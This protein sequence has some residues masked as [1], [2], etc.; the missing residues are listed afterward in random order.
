VPSNSSVLR[1]EHITLQKF[2]SDA[3]H[4]SLGTLRDSIRN[5]IKLMSKQTAL[6]VR[7][8]AVITCVVSY[9][10]MFM[11]YQKKT[12][13]DCEDRW[14]GLFVTDKNWKAYF[15]DLIRL[16]CETGVFGKVG[17]KRRCMNVKSHRNLSN[18]NVRR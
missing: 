9:A 6:T 3:L 16:E 10:Q 8:I 11:P 13:D 15:E 17:Q 1:T 14:W 2:C 5:F 18:K 7:R 12:G 4:K